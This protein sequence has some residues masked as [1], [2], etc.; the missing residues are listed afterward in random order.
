M[1]G[2]RAPKLHVPDLISCR[3]PLAHKQKTVMT[4]VMAV[5]VLQHNTSVAVENWFSLF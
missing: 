2:M 5:L 4:R 3:S 1:D